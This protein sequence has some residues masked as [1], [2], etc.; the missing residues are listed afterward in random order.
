MTSALG[1]KELKE[2]LSNVRTTKL[3]LN[4]LS[5]MFNDTKAEGIGHFLSLDRSVGEVTAVGNSVEKELRDQI[6]RV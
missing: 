3:R 5:V 2:I 4:K 6:E 1:P